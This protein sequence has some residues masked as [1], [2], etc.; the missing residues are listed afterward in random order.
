MR[1]A[2][3][4]VTRLQRWGYLFILPTLALFTLFLIY[5]MVSSFH[6]S[7]F[8]WNLLSPKQFVGIQNFIKMVRDPQVLNSFLRTIHFAV[9]SVL[10]INVLALAYALAFGSKLIRMKNL[11]QS[12]IFLPVVLSTVAIGIVWKFM[13]QTRGLLS[14]LTIQL[15]GVNMRWLTSTA[16]AP[17]SMIMVYVWKELGYYMVIY[18][19]GLLDIPESFFEAARVDGASPWQQLF[20]ITLPCLK[21]TIALALIACAIFTFGMFDIQY[22]ITA[23]GPSRSTEVLALNIYKQAFEFNKF[24]YASAVSVLFI[25]TLL[26][27][28]VLQLRLFRSQDT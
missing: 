13:F 1:K 15:L 22:V 23:G 9:L 20:R 3:Y 28:T 8:K 24:G 19:A 11:L 4:S 14:V 2:S 10:V 25:A 26:A 16:V 21:N 7:L 18:I 12:T 27:F 5:P 6:L 17:Y